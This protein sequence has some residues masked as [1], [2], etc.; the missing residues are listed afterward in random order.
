M[1]ELQKFISNNKDLL[2]NLSN[3]FD[4]LKNHPD[5]TE[6]QRKD[7]DSQI[8][9]ATENAANTSNIINDLKIKL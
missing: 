9:K 8:K 7:I 6:E 5:I 1:D 2:N 3:V 4:K